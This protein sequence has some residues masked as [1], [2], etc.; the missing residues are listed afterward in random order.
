MQ[1]HVYAVPHA[2]K[3]EIF[4]LNDKDFPEHISLEQNLTIRSHDGVKEG[5]FCNCGDISIQLPL[6]RGTQPSGQ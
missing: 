3:F 2:E 1:A 6:T 5:H 4:R